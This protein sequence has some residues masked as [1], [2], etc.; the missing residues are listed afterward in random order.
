MKIN[1]V[2]FCLLLSIYS[3][4]KSKTDTLTI[5]NNSKQSINIKYFDRV[6]SFGSASIASDATKT[7]IFA[8]SFSATL[9]NHDRRTF[10]LLSL[11]SDTVIIND[12]NVQSNSQKI[13]PL[14]FLISYDDIV[15]LSLVNGLDIQKTSEDIYAILSK[16]TI[17]SMSYRTLLTRNLRYLLFDSYLLNYNRHVSY[18]A[19]ENQ[20]IDSL[21]MKYLVLDQEINNHLYNISLVKFVDFQHGFKGRA[22]EDIFEYIDNHFSETRQSREFLI[23]NAIRRLIIKKR[24]KFIEKYSF[25]KESIQD[26]ILQTDLLNIYLTT[27]NLATDKT[28]L[29]RYSDLKMVAMD[30]LFKEF[31]SK[32]LIYD[33]SA[34][35]CSPCLD[36]I[37]KLLNVVKESTNTEYVI[38][39]VDDNINNWL[40][41]IKEHNL[42]S[43]HNYFLIQG[44]KSDFAKF[45]GIISIPRYMYVNNKGEI[46]DNNFQLVK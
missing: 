2:V 14:T 33:F 44:L 7:F 15:N 27:I 20:I 29:L 37:P 17:D 19:D 8:G 9:S 18:N 34:S 31:P 30:T 6:N 42:L 3:F 1:L 36:N 25:Y 28:M 45:H 35:W 12:S 39:S 21:G 10:Q 41:V 38:I 5:L 46:V 4:G 22:D 11:G 40:P 16:S 43:D 13:G 26:P 23:F 32:D 24:E